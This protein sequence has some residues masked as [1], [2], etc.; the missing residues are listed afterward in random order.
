MATLNAL[1]MIETKGLVAAIE[2]A[3][4]ALKAADVTVLVKENCNRSI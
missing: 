2:A 1:W 4:A 3:D